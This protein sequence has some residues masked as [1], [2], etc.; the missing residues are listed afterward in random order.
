MFYLF[1]CFR[2]TSNILI[3]AEHEYNSPAGLN[4]DAFFERFAPIAARFIVVAAANFALD[5]TG[6]RFC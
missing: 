2:E 3:D 1:L 5:F 4:V 6:V